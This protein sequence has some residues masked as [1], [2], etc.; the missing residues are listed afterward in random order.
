MSP[1]Y[2]KLKK[3]HNLPSFEV[4]DQELDL[5]DF[6][7][8]KNHLRFIV[9]RVGE[10]IEFFADILGGVLQPDSNPGSMYEAEGFSDADRDKVP[11]LYKKVMHLHREY[12]EQ[13]LNY[14]ENAYAAFI[15]QFFKEWADV[16]KDLAKVLV[17]MKKSW[18]RENKLKLDLGYYG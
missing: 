17:V 9:K 13:E 8:A 3:K 14:D 5:S 16:K 12:L 7:D 1:D 2:D 4:L 6:E 10:R 11:E 15:I 18:Q